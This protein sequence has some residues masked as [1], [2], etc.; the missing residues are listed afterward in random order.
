MHL[1]DD[2]YV[3]DRPLRFASPEVELATAEWIHRYK[4]HRLCEYCGDVPPIE[5]E[6]A[7]YVQFHRPAAS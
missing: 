1:Q 7:F 6:T 3:T 4:H 2:V 5:L